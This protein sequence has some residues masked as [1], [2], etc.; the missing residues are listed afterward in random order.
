MKNKRRRQLHLRLNLLRSEKTSL[1]N[2]DL[3]LK[4]PEMT[5]L[6][7]LIKASMNTKPRF[8]R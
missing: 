1:N 3:S 8:W 5:A 6:K 2:I 4:N 7:S